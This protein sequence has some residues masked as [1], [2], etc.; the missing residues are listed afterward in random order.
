L[1]SSSLFVVYFHMLSTPKAAPAAGLSGMVLCLARV[2]LVVVVGGLVPC[3]HVLLLLSATQRFFV[4]LR[5]WP[6]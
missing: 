1:I 6:F 3:A 2:G 5:C 4:A